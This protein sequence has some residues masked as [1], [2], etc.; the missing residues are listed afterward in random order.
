MSNPSRIFRPSLLLLMLSAAFLAE[1]VKA[2]QFDGLYVGMSKTQE[3]QNKKTWQEFYP[4]LEAEINDAFKQA[5][6][7]G[8]LLGMLQKAITLRL[9]QFLQA[10][11]SAETFL[12]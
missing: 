2:G 11:S 12:L 6:K 5:Q 7:T 8:L 9:I 3:E 4:G 1:Q 10:I